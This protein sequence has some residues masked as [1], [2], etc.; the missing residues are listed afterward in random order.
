[1]KQEFNDKK[2]CCLKPYI[3]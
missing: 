2:V 3:S 1:M